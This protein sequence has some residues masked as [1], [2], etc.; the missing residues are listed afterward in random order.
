[1]NI[2]ILKTLMEKENIS[3]YR[4]SKLSGIENKSIWNIVNNKRKDPQISTVVK[5]AKALDLNEH[6]FAELC[7]YKVN[8]QSCIPL[9]IKDENDTHY[10]GNPLLGEWITG[11]CPKCKKDVQLGMNYC[12]N[13]GQRLL[14]NEEE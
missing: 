3:M 1:M 6:E 14:W 9:E 12:S 8:K 7:D 10:G 13:C 2:N 5:I 4:L 11:T